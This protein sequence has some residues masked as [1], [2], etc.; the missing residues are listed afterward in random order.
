MAGS[1]KREVKCSFCGRNKSDV[2]VLIAGV[3]GHI[4]DNCITQAQSIIKEELAQKANVQLETSLV[5]QKPAEIKAFLDNF[6]IG[7][8]DAKRTLSVAVYNHYKRLLQETGD[9]GEDEVEIEKS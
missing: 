3:T 4:C 9:G 8:D 7:Q 5:L 6:V 2:N 1:E